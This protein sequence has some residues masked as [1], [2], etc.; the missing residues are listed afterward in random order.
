MIVGILAAVGV[1]KFMQLDN[2]ATLVVLRD[3][4][5]KINT[6][7]KQYWTNVKLSDGYKDDDQI[8][9]LVKPDLIDLCNWQVI[10]STGGIINAKHHSLQLERLPSLINQYAIWKEVSD[11][12]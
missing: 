12:G 10:S 4:V 3:A 1:H 11:G 2:S 7:E 6:V 8:F 9:Q 5:T